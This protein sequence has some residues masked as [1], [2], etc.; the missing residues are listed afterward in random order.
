MQQE[1]IEREIK[2]KIEDPKQLISK[3]KEKGAEFVGKA[4]Q[5]T[6]RFDDHS[7]SLDQRGIFLRTRSGFSNT[8]TV[9]RRI[10]GRGIVSEREEYEAE[11]EDIEVFR[12]MFVTLGFDW[13]RIMEKYRL[14]FKI[15]ETVVS[16]DELSIGF[17]MEIEGE[18]SKILETVALLGLDMRKKFLGSYWDIFYEETGKTGGRGEN[19]NFDEGYEPVLYGIVEDLSI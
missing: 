10:N 6:T 12:R 9:K 13:E 14:D 1:H 4:F 15:N 19:I 17:F 2:I 3:L 5:K 8:V 16:V 7:S 11:V 18:E